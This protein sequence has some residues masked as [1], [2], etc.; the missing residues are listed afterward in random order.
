MD[1]IVQD[2]RFAARSFMRSPTFTIVAVVTLGLG[3][4]AGTAVFSAVD[5]VLLRPLPYDNPSEL[6]F[7]GTTWD[8]PRPGWTSVPDFIDW[9]NRLT[10]FGSLAA[11]QPDAL[12][13]LNSGEPEQ[14]LMARVSPDFFSTLRAQPSP[15][16]VFTSD[17]HGTGAEPVAI[18]SHGLW[19]SRWGGERNTVGR[20]LDTSKGPV[21]IIGVMPEGFEPPVAMMLQDID[22]WF[23]LEVDAAAYAKNRG[24]RSLRVVGRLKQGV[25][26]DTAQREV[27]NLSRV[28]A[29][30][31]PEAYSWGDSKLGIGAVPLLEMTVGPSSGSSKTSGTS[32]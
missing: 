6:V 10:S 31:F 7:V 22:I 2:I 12:V 23:P 8:D 1:S 19:Q 32:T 15:G 11:S 4:G 3:I 26:L 20:V 9:K 13:L 21:R 29:V 5:G 16:R 18:L 17:E 25:P 14:L 27:E 28:M 30:E 24:G